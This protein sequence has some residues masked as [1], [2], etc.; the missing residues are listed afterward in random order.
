MMISAILGTLVIV[1][2]TAV[3]GFVVEKKTPKL[4]APKRAIRVDP[5]ETPETAVRALKP[6]RCCD[7]DMVRNLDDRVKFDGRDLLVA[8]FT[9]TTCAK[10]RSIYVDDR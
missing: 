7:R 1:G 4:E 2:I 5:G 8:R 6:Q 3:I 9:C 10:K